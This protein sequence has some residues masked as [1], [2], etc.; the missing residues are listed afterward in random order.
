MFRRAANSTSNAQAYISEKLDDLSTT[1]SLPVQEKDPNFGTNPIIKTFYEGNG[2]CDGYYNWVETPPKQLKEKTARA[3]DRVAIMLY[4]VKDL[5]KNTVGGRTPLKI[6]SIDVQSPLLTTALKPI[7]QEVGVFLDEH[8]VAKFAEPFKPLFFCYDKILALR[9]QAI[10]DVVFR[11][12]LHLLTQLMADLFGEM[13][14]KLRNLQQS[15][16]ISFKLAWT[17]FP[18]DS[19]IVAAA[20][21]CERLFQVLD[22]AYVHDAAGSRLEILC[23]H[24]V[25]TGAAFEWETTTLKIPSFSGNVP[26]SSLPIYPIEFHDDVEGL[27]ARLTTRGKKVFE[28]QGLEYRQYTGIGLD[29]K[30]RKYNVSHSP[31]HIVSTIPCPT[32]KFRDPLVDRLSHFAAVNFVFD[33]YS[34]Q[35]SASSLISDG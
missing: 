31:A 21:D 22:T 7:V 16:L 5:D 1:S 35:S 32:T 30:C 3:Y 34:H 8:D 14:K 24:I 18:K 11:E 23:Q 27:K 29:E 20:E 19:T 15:H 28:Y 17:Y 2:S 12:H 13:R 4:K 6:H 33:S 25:F 26:V 10:R 9:G